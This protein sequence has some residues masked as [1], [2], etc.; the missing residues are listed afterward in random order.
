MRLATISAYG[1]DNKRA[2]K[3]VVGIL[4][5]AGQQAPNPTRRWNTDTSDVRND[6]L[7]AAELAEWLRRVLEG[8]PRIAA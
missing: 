5:R 8:L 6:P 1:P 7:I 4:R 3:L 2:T